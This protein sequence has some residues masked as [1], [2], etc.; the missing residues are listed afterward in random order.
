MVWRVTCIILSLPLKIPGI[1][2][3]IPA[4]G[5]DNKKPPFS[6]FVLQ[7][8][9]RG[10]VVFI[11]GD[12]HQR[13]YRFRGASESFEHCE[14]MKTFHLSI[15]FR[16]GKQVAAWATRILGWGGTD[17]KKNPVRSIAVFPQWREKNPDADILKGGVHVRSDFKDE[18]FE[19][20]D[21]CIITRS[22]R[23]MVDELLQIYDRFHQAGCAMPAWAFL[24]AGATKMLDVAKIER[25]LKCAKGL[26]KLKI[27]GLNLVWDDFV[28]H[29]KEERKSTEMTLIGLVK[30]YG[31]ALPLQ[32]EQL[33]KYQ[34]KC[35]KDAKIL[36]STAHG[37]KGL[38]FRRVLLGADFN[39]PTAG[40]GKLVS[41]ENLRKKKESLA[42]FYKDEMNLFYVAVT[43]AKQNLYAPQEVHA[44][45]SQKFPEFIDPS[46]TKIDGKEPDLEGEDEEQGSLMASASAA[47]E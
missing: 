43:R 32:I 37:C 29:C 24:K 40:P 25:Y 10:I 11:I 35:T 27:D 30:A 3:F 7:Q 21:T 39:L 6:A 42:R 36:L 15:S 44:I 34:V 28:D 33:K 22:N 20:G 5:F 47:A 2:T 17:I 26:C 19:E 12:P 38:E 41:F 9:K 1:V 18:M 8:A 46:A 23:S 4:N 45:F 16:F 14:V 31:D 13:I